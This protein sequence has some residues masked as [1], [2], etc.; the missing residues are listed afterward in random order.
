[1]LRASE[2]APGTAAEAGF[3]LVEVLMGASVL[4]VA[5]M[6]FGV[7]M[8]QMQQAAGKTTALNMAQSQLHLAFQRLD[9]EIRYASAIG[10]PAQ[11][12]D[13]W[14]VE[15]LATY[16]GAAICTELRLRD[17]RLEQRAWTSGQQAADAWNPLAVDVAAIG[18]PFVLTPASQDGAGYQRLGINL[19]ASAGG[20]RDATERR[21][22]V[23]FTALNTSID[24]TPPT[25]CAQQRPTP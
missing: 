20:P 12:G 5:L 19:T 22:T 6:I 3:T 15:F 7:G 8:V 2:R 16:T 21:L 23:T 25:P 14:Y 10:E 18:A 17:G 9:K 24:T 13:S 11:V 4:G 1:M